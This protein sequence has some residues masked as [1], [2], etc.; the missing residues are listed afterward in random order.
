M[1]DFF[2]LPPEEPCNPQAFQPGFL[3][4]AG[5]PRLAF[6]PPIFLRLLLKCLDPS[7]FLCQETRQLPPL[8]R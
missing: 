4:S 6:A 8:F 2:A 1:K 3:L 5:L 7:N